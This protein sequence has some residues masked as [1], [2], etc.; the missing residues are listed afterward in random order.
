MK[1]VH[2]NTAEEVSRTY[3]GEHE[4]IPAQFEEKFWRQVAKTML[5]LASIRLLKIGSI[6]R[7]EAD[8]DSFV[9]GPLVETG[10]G[11]YDSAAEFYEDYPLALG[12]SLGKGEPS[13]NGQEELIQAFQSL[14]TSFP[15]PTTQ[16]GDGSFAGFGLANYDLNPNNFL[17]DREFNVLAVIDWDSVITVPDAALYRFPFLMGISCTVPGVV[18]T[19][20]AVMKRQQLSRRF[21]E[22]VEAVGRE[23]GGN[24]CG[25]ASKRRAFL[26]TK[27]GFFSKESVAFRSLIYVKM[28][29]DWVNYTWLQGLKWLSE[30]N[31]VEVAQ[32]YLEG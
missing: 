23:Q 25:D 1:Y 7:D 28:R 4:G 3:P 22:V 32:F 11:P 15:S 26:L 20:P 9:V 8:P 21:A 29:Q 10:S 2:G 14:A 24:D 27:A 13:V 30:H 12:K 5:Q 31:K 17:V 18:D 6:I 19:H 16:A